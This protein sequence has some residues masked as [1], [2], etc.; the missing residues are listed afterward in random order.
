MVGCAADHRPGMDLDHI[1]PDKHPS[2][3]G[4]GEYPPAVKFEN[5]AGKSTRAERGTM[6]GTKRPFVEA[7]RGDPSQ[8]VFQPLCK[9]CHPRKSQANGDGIYGDH[10]GAKRRKNRK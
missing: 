10:N 2:G 8:R 3:T 6:A 1:D 5:W 7:L 9:I 4:P